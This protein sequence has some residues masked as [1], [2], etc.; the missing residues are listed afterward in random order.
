MICSLPSPY[1][2]LLLQVVVCSCLIF[3]Q[4]N[5]CIFLFGMFTMFPPQA[6]VC[7]TQ[8]LRISI[9]NCGVFPPKTLVCSHQQ[10]QTNI[11]LITKKSDLFPPQ[12]GMLSLQTA[13]CSHP[14][15]WYVPTPNCG[16]FPPQTGYVPTPGCGMLSS[17]AVVYFHLKL[18]CSYPK[19][20]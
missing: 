5:P 10:K 13:L 12:T 4:P 7:S 1:G 16:M 6:V 17:Q 20:W 2:M 14:K 9:Q 15:K 8:N 19:L 3:C 18:V 11:Q